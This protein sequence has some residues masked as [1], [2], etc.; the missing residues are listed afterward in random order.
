MS[1]LAFLG[2]SHP[3]NYSF[4]HIEKIVLESLQTLPNSRGRFYQD[5]PDYFVSQPE[6]LHSTG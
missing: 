3:W 6:K 4:L 5:Q 1:D 2:R